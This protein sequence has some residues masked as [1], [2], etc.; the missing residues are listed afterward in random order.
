[1]IDLKKGLYYITLTINIVITHNNNVNRAVCRITISVSG[2]IK[3]MML[4]IYVA[5]LKRTDDYGPKD[6]Q[7]Y[8]K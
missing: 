1:M 4:M 3:C 2:N 7:Y 6:N 8:F 5:K